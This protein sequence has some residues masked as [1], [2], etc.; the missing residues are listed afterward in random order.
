MA[1]AAVA[2][3]VVGLAL[4]AKAGA[5]ARAD[6]EAIAARKR[7]AAEFE[8]Q[9]LDQ[10]AGQA[11][12]AAQRTL[13]SEGRQGKL[14]QS[15]A[16]AL[17]AASGGSASDPTVVKI[18]SGIASE[19]AY[20]QNLAMYQ[21]EEKAR[22]LHIAAAADRMSGEIDAAA[23]LASGRAIETETTGRILGTGASMYARYGYGSP[24]TN[25]NYTAEGTFSPYYT[26]GTPANPSYG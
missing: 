11:I 5:D 12:A 6:A 21:G 1:V 14:V 7:Q 3:A 4:Q 8:A 2:V 13:F 26:G 9:Q 22:Q 23:S 10:Q 15:R 19:S 20:R 25:P 16:I 17:A 24:A 18:V